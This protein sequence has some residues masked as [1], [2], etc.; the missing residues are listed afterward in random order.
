MAVYY[1]HIG[2]RLSARDFPLSLGTI[3]NGL[4]RFRFEDIEPFIGHLAPVELADIKSKLENFAPTGC[5]IWGIPSGA[6]RV[7]KNMN[8]GDFLMLLES[9]AFAYCGQVIHR[10]SELCYDLSDNIWGEQRFPIIILLQGE[11]ISYGWDQFLVDFDFAAN[12]HMRGNTANISNTRMHASS[13]VTE[14]RFISSILTTKGSNPVDQEID[15]RAFAEGLE[16]HLREVKEWERHHL[17][18]ARVFSQTE[19]KCAFCDFNVPIALE[20]AHIVPKH[21]QGSDDPRNGIVLCAI[22]HRLFDANA[23]GIDPSD[24]RI[25]CNPTWDLELLRISRQSLRHLGNKPHA[26]ALQWRWERF[27]AWLSKTS[28]PSTKT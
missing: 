15:F 18:R 6:Q 20:A 24:L 1:Q 9:I 8:T 5:Q 17:F 11:L 28:H 19:P 2:E 16:A 23:I 27:S 22:H 21:E 26:D 13:F 14:E 4:K 12:Y 7:L 10:V 25:I 3:A